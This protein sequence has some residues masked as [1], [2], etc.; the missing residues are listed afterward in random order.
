MGWLFDPTA[1]LG[2]L[3]LTAL[4]V[5]LAVDSLV[6]IT[7]LSAK[8][9]PETR[10]RVRWLSLFWFVVCSALLTVLLVWV[11]RFDAPVMTVGSIH[12]SFKDVAYLLGGLYLLKQATS[13]LMDYGQG[14]SIASGDGRVYKS[15]S[16]V[17]LQAAIVMALLSL[18]V[19]VLSLA[20]SNEVVVWLAACLIGATVVWFAFQPLAQLMNINRGV[21]VL[22]AGLV[23]M[24]GF[25]LLAKPSVVGATPYLHAALIFS[26]LIAAA[27]FL[28]QRRAIAPQVSMRE[29]MLG[30]V[31]QMLGQKPHEEAGSDFSERPESEQTLPLAVEQRN[32]MSGVLTLSE[33]SVHS[34][35]T[36][37]T[38]V[39][40][41][42]IDDEPDRIRE[43]IEQ[44]PHSFFPVCRG[45]FDE[46]IGIGRAKRMIADLLTH[47]RIQESRLREPII[48][49]DT[50]DIMRLIGTL[51]NSRGQLVLIAD[52]FGT[53][54]GLVTPIDVFEAIAGEF[55]D[56]DESPDI[57]PDGD[58]RWRV[59][60]A[61]DLH[62]LEQELD[63]EGL[64]NEDE[65]YTTLAGYL[66]N[67]F[68]RLPSVGEGFNYETGSS[69]ITFKVVRLERRRI[70]MVYVE[71]HDRVA[72]QHTGD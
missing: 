72:D 9:T 67:H 2:L 40:W 11:L 31:L 48:V 36:P 13:D 37:R 18:E 8:L 50:I 10:E 44:A 65:E 25:A 52:E 1:W 56:E 29:R 22:T 3:I 20:I 68:G 34:I 70:A 71:R 39:S 47:G 7:A 23:L 12:L 16:Q 14:K 57:V 41:I 62:I 4:V 27:W 17:L 55:P 69:V 49:H 33:R 32:M 45:S 46:I 6:L 42:D 54:E 59:D 19:V 21:L 30:V 26:V 43:Q 64:V 61:A 51:K 5:V 28:V 35:M 58:N 38:E 15:L 60:G 53:I 24:S 66:L 63:I